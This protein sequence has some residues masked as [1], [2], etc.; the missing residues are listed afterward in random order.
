MAVKNLDYTD[1]KLV[2]EHGGF[3]S[4]RA[5]MV[6]WGESPTLVEFKEQSTRVSTTIFDAMKS[7]ILSWYISEIF[8]AAYSLE[9]SERQEEDVAAASRKPSEQ[10]LLHSW[11]Q[12]LH[13]HWHELATKFMGKYVAIWDDAVFD[14][15]ENLGALAERVYTALGY[16]PIFMPYIGEKEQVYEFISPV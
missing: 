11:D 15:D 12:Y 6:I 8:S 4:E 7:H 9:I 3:R 2:D 16:R 10:D 14:S 1:Q 13:E 5:D